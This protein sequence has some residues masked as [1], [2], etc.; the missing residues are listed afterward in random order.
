MTKGGS[1]SAFNILS[2]VLLGLTALACLCYTTLFFVPTL[3]GP[4][5]GPT[6]VHAVQLPTA[7]PTEQSLPPTWTPTVPGPPTET[8]TPFTP[9]TPEPTETQ[10]PTI[11]PAPTRTKT[12]TPGPSPT[13]SATRSKY[14]YTAAVT[15]QIDPAYGCGGSVV[16]GSITDLSGQPVTG[17]GM[18]IHVEG[19]ADVDTGG[20]LHPGEE[21]RGNKMQ[22]ASPYTGVVGPSAWDVV[23]NLSGTT[24]GTW[25]VWLIQGRQVSDQIE[26]HLSGACGSST[27]IVRFQ[28]NH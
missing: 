1:G 14:P 11:T 18:I 24:A 3:A 8:S 5:A 19:D 13:A 27:A 9:S 23:I 16:L 26:V 2:V 21:W 28:Q 6:P 7:T 12:V 20:A 15:Y 25:R 4:F 17:G 22:G 10:R